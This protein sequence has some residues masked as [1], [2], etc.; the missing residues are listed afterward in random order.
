MHVVITGATGLIGSA[1]VPQLVAR[2]DRVTALVRSAESVQ[3][4]Q[5][6][7]AAGALIDFGDRS[8]IADAFAEGDAVIHLAA[9]GD[10]AEAFDRRVAEAAIQ[11]LGGTGKPYAHTGGVWVYGSGD[12]LTEETPYDAPAI[13]R[14]RLAVIGSLEAADLALTVLH[15]GIVYGDGGSGIPQLLGGQPRTDDGALTTLGR[16]EQ[17]WTTVHVD[18]LAAL[19]V[20]VVAS[21]TGHGAVL[22]VSGVNPSVADLSSV[23]AGDAGVIGEDPV[24]TRARL[25]DGFA[26]ALL[27]DQQ[28]SGAKARGIGGWTPTRPTLAE[29]LGR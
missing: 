4:V 3:K 18:D 22:G 8:A 26:E 2:G 14:W 27:L 29:E 17:H 5:S 28:A 9:A 20:A 25:G 11:A 13:T 1:V 23:I 10:D 6:A 24:A 7:G 19:Y 21:G 16:G 15:P 12:D